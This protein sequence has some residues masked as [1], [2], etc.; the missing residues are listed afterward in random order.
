MRGR[1]TKKNKMVFQKMKFYRFFFDEI[2]R[3]IPL[4]KENKRIIVR[5]SSSQ[6][7]T[8]IFVL[9]RFQD[10]GIDILL[11]LKRMQKIEKLLSLRK[12]VLKT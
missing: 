7:L 4:R 10:G 11:K 2:G 12:K 6:I 8:S 1:E 3:F 9:I 5:V